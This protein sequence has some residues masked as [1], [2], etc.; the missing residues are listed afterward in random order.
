MV[1]GIY[2]KYTY[3]ALGRIQSMVY[4]K[5]TRGWIPYYIYYTYDDSGRII[6]KDAFG[7]GQDGIG[8]ASYT[9][10]SLGNISYEHAFGVA[11]NYYNYDLAG[12]R[13]STYNV[14]GTTYFTPTN[15]NRLE[16]WGSNGWMT[17]NDA[18]CVNYLTR[19]TKTNII[20]LELSWNGEYQLTQVIAVDS[21]DNYHYIYYTYDSLGRKIS[22]KESDGNNWC[23][24]EYY[25]YDG[26]NL[27]ADYDAINGSVIRTYTYGPGVDDIQSMTTY[28]GNE[29]PKTYYYIKDA[30]NT[31][32]VLVDETGLIVEYYYYDAFGNVKMRDENYQWMTKSKCGNRFLFQGREYDYDT[33]LYYFR[34][35]WYEPETGRWL[36]PDPIGISGGL[37]LYAFCGNDPVNQ[38][39]PMGLWG[40]E[41]DGFLIGSGNPWLA[42]DASTLDTMWNGGA[43]V[44][45]GMIPWF[46]P[47]D[48]LCDAYKNECGEY[49]SSYED[50]YNIGVW[51]GTGIDLLLGYKYKWYPAV[52]AGI[53]MKAR[54]NDSH[55][56][57]KK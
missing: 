11:T 33:A 28:E 23:K 9:Y 18:G 34:N 13:T 36:S 16:T 2:C 26:M 54:F 12:N 38:I 29:G 42:F 22:R 17:Y 4:N 7:G 51:V 8:A 47:F 44:I 48:T 55:K 53:N 57:F 40:I 43:A 20:N 10:D 21:S 14:F 37:N 50:S 46:N 56:K 32:H 24:K 1:S 41:V 6:M 3:D 19:N 31:V 45:D 35:R 27:V 5:S 30:S 52:A 39:D 49:D 15:N 25:I